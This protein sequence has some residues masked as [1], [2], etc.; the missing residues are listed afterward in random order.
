MNTRLIFLYIFKSNLIFV[1]IEL[2]ACPV[3]PRLFPPHQ[4]ANRWI[5]GISFRMPFT[6]ANSILFPCHVLACHHKQTVLEGHVMDS[7]PHLRSGNAPTAKCRSDGNG[8]P[9]S[10]IWLPATRSVWGPSLCRRLVPSLSESDPRLAIRSPARPPARRPW[11]SPP[12]PRISRRPSEG[13]EATVL[14]GYRV[15]WSK[16]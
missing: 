3:V 5:L 15:K 7:C 10:A 13:D 4:W 16:K 1:W 9:L 2:D 14:K 6:H 8:P 11:V 12:G